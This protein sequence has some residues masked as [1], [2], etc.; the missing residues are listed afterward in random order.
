M[1]KFL[2]KTLAISF[3]FVSSLIGLSNSNAQTGTLIANPE[4]VTT[5]PNASGTGNTAI[6]WT[7]SG[8]AKVLITHQSST[9]YVTTAETVV[10][11]NA[12]LNSNNWAI[13]YIQ[14]GRIHTFR[15]YSTTAG[16]S[17]PE[18]LLATAVVIGVDPDATGTLTANPQ[19]VTDYPNS[20]GTGNTNLSWSSLNNNRTLI[21]L[22]KT[23]K[24]GSV[25]SPETLVISNNIVTNTI[26][27][28]Y[29]QQGVIHTFKLYSGVPNFD[30]RGAL[31][32]TTVV[33]AQ[34]LGIDSKNL[35]N[36]GVSVYN[37][38][39]TNQFGIHIIDRDAKTIELS[40]FDI[41]GKMISA[42][43]IISADTDFMYDASSLQK[44][45]YLLQVIID[46][47][48]KVVR[49]IVKI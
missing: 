45:V 12:Q 21:T 23:R 7:S 1:K 39:S 4:S 24:D 34:T 20:N 26:N 5:Y 42:P 41:S 15:L 29:I 46:N 17:T 35:D 48:T 10:I 25:V 28:N 37:G 30:V 47:K 19:T 13:N 49:K 27:I 31:L 8:A 6:T 14:K 16:S 36:E 40:V 22:T 3:I 32:A 11:N 43:Q 9:G 2:H 33:T 38:R 44:G 18:T